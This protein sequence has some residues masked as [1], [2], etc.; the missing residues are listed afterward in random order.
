MKHHICM[1]FGISSALYSNERQQIGGTGQGNRFSGDT[2]RDIL[3][4]VIK[5]VENKE[6]GAIIEL[7]ISEECEQRA[8]ICICR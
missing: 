2:S 4:F 3:Y 6:L 1:A 8:A 7:P 5:E